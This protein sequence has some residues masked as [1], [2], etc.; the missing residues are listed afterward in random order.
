MIVSDLA[1]PADDP[2]VARAERRLALLEELAEIGM[3]IARSLKP[4]A[5]VEDAQSPGRDP[6]AAFAQVSRA[7][8]LT[9]ALEAKTEAELRDWRAGAPARREAAEAEAEAGRARRKDRVEDLVLT[10]ISAEAQD[11]EEF[12]ELYE[13]LDERLERDAAY[14]DFESRPLRDTV[15]RLCRD[16]ALAPDWSRW[17]EDGWEDYDPPTRPRGSPFH[18]PSRK[19]LL[20]GDGKP[21]EAA[22]A[23]DPAQRRLE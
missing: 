7:V 17:A 15:E 23:P 4:G 9:L 3:A 8:R 5:E 2:A 16:L 1:D 13:A 20:D 19:P 14:S 11:N 21:L 22:A 6:A 12:G 10:V 18:Q